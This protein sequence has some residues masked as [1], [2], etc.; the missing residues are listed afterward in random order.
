MVLL[1][2]TYRLV[3]KKILFF[4]FVYYREIGLGLR[5]GGGVFSFVSL[6]GLMCFEG[7]FGVCWLLR[8][9]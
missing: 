1:S 7:G 4:I 5:C 6:R 9:C 8:Q 3:Y 2:Q